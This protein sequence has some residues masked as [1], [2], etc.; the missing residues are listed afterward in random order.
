[1]HGCSNVFCKPGSI[2]VMIMMMIPAISIFSYCGL[3]MSLNKDA[4]QTG[5]VSVLRRDNNQ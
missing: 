4:S 1:M 2:T 3:L 5:L